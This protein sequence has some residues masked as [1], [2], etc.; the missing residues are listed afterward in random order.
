[1]ER[2]SERLGVGETALAGDDLDAEIF[3][4]EEMTGGF[5]S[6]PL[7]VSSGRLAD[8]GAEPPGEVAATQPDRRREGRH[9]EIRSRRSVDQVAGRPDGGRRGSPGPDLRAELRLA[10]G[11]AQRHHEMPGHRLSHGG[12]AVL[13]DHRQRQV[14]PRRHTGRGPEVTVS[15]PY[16]VRI[17]LDL[18][19]ATG[20][21]VGPGPVCG[22]PTTLAATGRRQQERPRAHRGQSSGSDRGDPCQ[23]RS[24]HVG[25][26][27]PGATRDQH[28]VG[29]RTNRV[30]G[31]IG[32]QDQAGLR[33]DRAAVDR[34]QEEPVALPHVMQ[35]LHALV[36][37]GK[38]L[39]RADHV[40]RLHTWEQRE[41]DRSHDDSKALPPHGVNDM[42]PT[43][44]DMDRFHTARSAS[45]AWPVSPSTPPTTAAPE[46]ARRLLIRGEELA[47]PA[48]EVRLRLCLVAF[49]MIFTCVVATGLLTGEDVFHVA[50]E[51]A[52]LV[53]LVAIGRRSKHRLIAT[54]SVSIGLAGT[55]AQ[56]VHYTDGLIEAH[57]AF[58]V[59]LPL[60]SIFQDWRA[61][62]VAAG[63]V[64]TH[65]AVAG[66]LEPAA[67]YNHPAAQANPLLWGG[68]HGLFVFAEV[69]A[70]LTLWHFATLD[71]RTTRAALSALT[72][73]QE[74]LEFQAM[75]DPLTGLGNRASLF[76]ALEAAL[77]GNEPV[78]LCVVDIDRFQ[79]INES[80]GHELGDQLLLASAAR[81]EQC[82]RAED[83][84]VRIG[85]DEFVV[86]THAPPS[87]GGATAIGDR[88]RESFDEPLTIDGEAFPVSVS[89]GVA[90]SCGAGERLI[91]DPAVLLRN[92]DAA[93]NQAKANGR[94]TVAEFDELL[95]TEAAQ[96]LR[97]KKDLHIAVA[98]R[99]FELHYQPV[100]DFGTHALTGVE[101]L[102]RWP[103]PTRGR[104]S[105]D[106][107]IP[108]AEDTG[109][110]IAIGA[111]VLEEGCTQAMSWKR[112]HGIELD[113]AINISARQLA[114]AT[115]PATVRS[116]I[117]S[118]GIDPSRVCLEITETALIDQPALAIHNL[119]RL[120]EMGLDIALDDFGTSY[121]S[122][123]YLRTLPVTQIK[124]D[125][126]FTAGLTPGSR[127]ATIIESTIDL[128]HGL[129]LAVVAEGIETQSHYDMLGDF[130]CD[131]GQ[132]FHM[133]RPVPAAELVA[134]QFGAIA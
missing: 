6:N 129:G 131:F 113:V 109:V 5:D 96:R 62:T 72:A 100:F 16:G 31:Q 49:V 108:L 114:S 112:D 20:E 19:V 67:V 43:D 41:D 83:L 85:A 94:N 73:A 52:P 124:I 103:H 66:L 39:S 25:I 12:T 37:P 77:A 75:H 59:I 23:E 58:F 63:L 90:G 76:H 54:M 115:F 28:G 9:G 89:V 70:L 119:G 11:S 128:A 46:R 38:D 98:E 122:L 92:A 14:D 24:G 18:G 118:T 30:E 105:P 127:D 126:S 3:G 132:G 107:F 82:V 86:L 22:D 48:F 10:T 123:T 134:T 53:V 93:L 116:I 55:A 29:L 101:A 79:L 45:D 81:L 71:H 44:R 120:R 32:D 42:V 133:G 65:H 21:L 88:L 106:E 8:L 117:E 26:A 27:G 69:V 111:W 61:T 40:E 99:S 60:I 102:I 51:S 1:M 130:G 35:V 17:D 33:Q 47:Q 64:L 87:T 80:L 74:E 56:L 13:L 15:D 78:G 57:F 91:A 50:A 125:R 2:S 104:I 121:A 7:H 84:L 36:G 97:L 68:S 95:R 34:G 4:F 110:I